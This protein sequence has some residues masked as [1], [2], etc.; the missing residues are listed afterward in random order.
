MVLIFSL[1]ICIAVIVI[2]FFW[3]K[4]PEMRPL[5]TYETEELIPILDHFDQKKINYELIGNTIRVPSESYAKLKLSLTRAGLQSTIPEGDDILLTDMGF[6]TSQRVEKE[7]LKLSRERQLARAIE[8]FKQIRRAQVL[9]ATPKES[10]FVRHRQMASASVFL[11]LLPNATLGQSEISA[12]VDMVSTAVPG[13]R[14][15]KVTVTNQHGR[16][17]NS[18]TEDSASI[19]QRKEYELEQKQ[20]HILRKKIDAI[21]IPVLGLGQ[22]TAEVDI[23]M[24]FTQIEETQKQ[25]DPTRPAMRSEFTVEDS[26]QGRVIGGIPGALSNQPPIESAIPEDIKTMQTEGLS[27]NGG[28]SHKEATRNYELDTTIRHKRGQTSRIARQTVSVAV[29]YQSVRDPVSGDVQRQALQAVDIDKL[30]R[31]LMGGIGFQASRGDVLEVISV[32][33]NTP[34]FTNVVNEAIWDHPNFSQWMRW[35]IAA[36]VIIIVLVL[37]RPALKNLLYPDE[38]AVADSEMKNNGLSVTQQG[39]DGEFIASGQRLDETEE[40]EVDLMLSLPDLHKDEDFL[41]AVRALVANEPDLAAQV[42]QH[43]IDDDDKG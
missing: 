40:S 25:F 36:L 35:V 31:L 12:I 2:V 21:L 30:R 13:L 9:L 43:W 3:L 22:Y 33:F 18:G 7:R 41:K 39:E 14:P 16:L 5:G 32:S 4:E 29:D 17:L 27:S 28:S 19:A 42:V 15:N 8:Q 20:E 11:T 23:S 6:G 10:V 26:N 34:E 37:I 24:D 38:I 1:A